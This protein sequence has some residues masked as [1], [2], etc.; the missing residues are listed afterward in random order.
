GG[1]ED[2]PPPPPHLPPPRR[3]C[4]HHISLLLDEDTAAA[5]SSSSLARPDLARGGRGLRR[6]SGHAGLAGRHRILLTAPLLLLGRRYAPPAGRAREA[7][8]DA[9]LDSYDSGD[10]DVDLLFATAGATPSAS[11]HRRQDMGTL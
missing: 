5:S 11:V 1:D 3:R 10:H 2:P 7:I 8:Y 9:V 6:Q 4:H